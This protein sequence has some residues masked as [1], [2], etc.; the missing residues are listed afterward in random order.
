VARSVLANGRIWIVAL[1]IAAAALAMPGLLCADLRPAPDTAS[2]ECAPDAAADAPQ[3]IKEAYA[4]LL[5]QLIG[6]PFYHALSSKFGAARSCSPR[7]DSSSVAVTIEFGPRARLSARVNPSSELSEQR[8]DNPGFP[9][10]RVKMLLRQQA[11]ATYGA[12]ACGIDWSRPEIERSS[13][14]HATTDTIYRGDTCNC[15][16][17]LRYDKSGLSQVLLRSTC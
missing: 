3:A 2:P 12:N 8:L 7:F 14:A 4:T 1:P 16:A 13:G 6:S 17:R 10:A 11:E 15:Q 9:R 5:K